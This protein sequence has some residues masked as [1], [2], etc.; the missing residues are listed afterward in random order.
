MTMAL[1][2]DNFITLFAAEIDSITKTFVL[3]GYKALSSF[4]QAPLGSLLVLYIVLMGYGITRGLIE[5]PQQELFRFAFRAG[6]IYMTAMDWDIF[7]SYIRDLIVI[8]SEGIA[9]HMMQ[10]LGK[11]SSG[12]SINQSLQN[13]LN[14]ILGL[15]TDLLKAGSLRNFSPYFA[16]IMVLL[17]G[18]LTIGLA[19]IEIVVAKIMLA[20]CLS[21]A[22]LFII[23]TLF[24]QT[25]SFFERWLGTLAGFSFGIIFVSAVVGLCMHLLHWI[26]GALLANNTEL[27]APIW[28]PI[29]IVSCL[30]LFALLEAVSIGKSIGGSVSSSNGAA[31]VGGLLAFG[32]G[33]TSSLKNTAEKSKDLTRM[34][35]SG[36]SNL[37]EKGAQIKAASKN[38][39]K[40]LHKNLRR[41]SHD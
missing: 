26:T 24:E 13:V 1:N 18:S 28:I 25:K 16:G 38:L 2:Y 4:L 10:A 36:T 40:Q 17:S 6:L 29:F 32:L 14:E 23:F 3:D 39:Y 15:G 30:C 27:T 21:T 8:G 20:V 33:A 31:M 19:F 5:R 11:Q 35:L 34:G 12:S 41:G 37:F 9:S 22:P 7:A